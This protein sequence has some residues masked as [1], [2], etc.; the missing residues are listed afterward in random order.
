V[1]FRAATTGNSYSRSLGWNKFV[2]AGVDVCVMP[3]GHAAMMKE[4]MVRVLAEKLETYLAGTGHASRE[5]EIRP[6]LVDA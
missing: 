2:T 3:A 1:L 5:P 4:P 6:M